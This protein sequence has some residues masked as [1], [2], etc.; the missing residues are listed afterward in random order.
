MVGCKA[1]GVVETLTENIC[2]QIMAARGMSK[3]ALN[4][5]RSPYCVSMH[6]SP[7][8]IVTKPHAPKRTLNHTNLYPPRP[9]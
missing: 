9:H 6:T 4:Y 3:L 5:P 1:C 2:K 8:A 7:H